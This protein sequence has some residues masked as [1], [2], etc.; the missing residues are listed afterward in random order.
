MRHLRPA[1]FARG[2]IPSDSAAIRS[3]E[4]VDAMT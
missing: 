1:E 3:T 4:D 2:R